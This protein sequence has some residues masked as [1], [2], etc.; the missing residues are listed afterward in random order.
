MRLAEAKKSAFLEKVIFNRQDASRLSEKANAVQPHRAA[1]LA[2]VRSATSNDV[3]LRLIIDKRHAGESFEVK[4]QS[5][6]ITVPSINRSSGG[7]LSCEIC[8]P[9]L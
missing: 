2:L 1:H 6:E 5:M 3:S 8:V 9:D 7:G 4:I